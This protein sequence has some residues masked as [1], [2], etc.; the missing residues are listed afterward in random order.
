MQVRSQSQEDPL[1][2]GMATTPVFLP[3]ESHGPRNL[4]GY[5]PWG[6]KSVISDWVHTLLLLLRRSV[7]SDS[8]R[9]HRRQ[10]T[11]LLCPWDLQAR[12]LEW[13]SISFS[14]A[15]KW[16]VEVKLLS[17]V[18]L[19]ETPRTAAYQAPPSMGFSSQEDWSGLPCFNIKYILI[20]SMYYFRLWTNLI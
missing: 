8:V 6:H 17:H 2:K 3:G 16:K 11:R 15:W 5:S 19:F 20:Y 1:E 4:L 18:R 7:V 10:P 12:T 13:V 9:P 14:S